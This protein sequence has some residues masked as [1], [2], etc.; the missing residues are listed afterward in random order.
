MELKYQHNFSCSSLFSFLLLCQSINNQRRCGNP[1]HTVSAVREEVIVLQHVFPFGSLS[2]TRLQSHTY[3]T[4]V[5]K[6]PHM[7]VT[8][9]KCHK[10]THKTHT[11]IYISIKLLAPTQV[12]CS[13]A[14]WVTCLLQERR[15]SGVCSLRYG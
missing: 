9:T 7:Q 15:I 4:R 6:R 14:L 1:I 11:H 13:V 10:R 12:A 3:C 5:C 8:C 2:S